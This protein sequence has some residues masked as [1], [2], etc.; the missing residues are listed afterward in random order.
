[1]IPILTFQRKTAEVKSQRKGKK[2]T[3]FKNFLMTYEDFVLYVTKILI[4]INQIMCKLRVYNMRD[5]HAP[6]KAQFSIFMKKVT[7]YKVYL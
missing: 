1:M 4:E 7:V 2:V 3:C 5:S 6:K